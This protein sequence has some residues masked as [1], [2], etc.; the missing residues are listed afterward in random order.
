[1][2][3]RPLHLC[4][5]FGS[6]H[7]PS[8][9]GA[10]FPG[11]GGLTA[12][13]TQGPAPTR[14]RHCRPAGSPAVSVCLPDS[15]LILL[16]FLHLICRRAWW[17]PLAPFRLDL[18]AGSFSQ[19]RPL[20]LA[21]LAANLWAPG[22]LVVSSWGRQLVGARFLLIFLHSPPK[23]SLLHLPFPF[24]FPNFSSGHLRWSL[25]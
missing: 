16:I 11:F 9:P 15:L 3:L 12:L 24:S 5:L 1:M 19:S 18:G 22:R 4:E 2:L 21:G 25:K 8:L 6:W 23:K 13:G 17:L 14:Q 7:Y 10:T 20:A